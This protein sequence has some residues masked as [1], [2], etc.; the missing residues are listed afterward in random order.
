MIKRFD[1]PVLFYISPG[2]IAASAGKNRKGQE[3]PRLLVRE[4]QTP[5]EGKSDPS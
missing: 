5:R 3:H 4:S 1:F 2:L